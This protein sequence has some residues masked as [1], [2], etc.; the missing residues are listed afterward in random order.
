MCA[1]QPVWSQLITRH[2]S[3]TARACAHSIQCEPYRSSRLAEAQRNYTGDVV[4][5]VQRNTKIENK[6]TNKKC[7]C[8]AREYVVYINLFCAPSGTCACANALPVH[9]RAV[10]KLAKC[11]D[12]RGRDTPNFVCILCF[13]VPH[14]A[15]N[16]Y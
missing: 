11:N 9:I 5:F 4:L 3:C 7:R 8:A 12:L 10:L 1:P 16:Y 2:D 14:S 13:S 15:V 6:Q